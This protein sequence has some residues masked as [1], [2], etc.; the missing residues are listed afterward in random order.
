[1]H[2]RGYVSPSTKWRETPPLPSVSVTCERNASWN[3]SGNGKRYKYEARI[4][5]L[6]RLLDKAHAENEPL[7]KAFAMT[8][9]KAREGKI[10]MLT[11]RA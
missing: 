8:Q 4:A 10:N 1:L 2:W 3:F 9:K 6:E 11:C 5:E 7:K